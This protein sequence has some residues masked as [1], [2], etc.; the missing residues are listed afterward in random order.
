MLVL[1]L[2]HLYEWCNG[3][4]AGGPTSA[5]ITRVGPVFLHSNLISAA[6]RLTKGL[7]LFL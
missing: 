6:E 2:P 1:S 4:L 3:G 5:A 7:R